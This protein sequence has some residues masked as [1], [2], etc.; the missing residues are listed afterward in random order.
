MLPQPCRLGLATV[1]LGRA[2]AAVLRGRPKH[3]LDAPEARPQCSCPIMLCRQ[4][5]LEAWG[6]VYLGLLTIPPG[7]TL[8]R[9][10]ADICPGLRETGSRE[11]RQGHGNAALC[12]A[13]VCPFPT[14]GL[15]PSGFTPPW[16]SGEATPGR[17]GSKGEGE[18]GSVSWA[19]AAAVTAAQ[20]GSGEP[21]L[22]GWSF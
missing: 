5:L 13:R 16:S 11:G 20:P 9:D 19:P 2:M 6:R 21:F 10:G 14:P 22:L 17:E 12:W 3:P 18:G 1:Q 8:S 7:E 15:H 4:C